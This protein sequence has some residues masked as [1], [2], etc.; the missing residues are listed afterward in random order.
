MEDKNKKNISLGSIF[1]LLISLILVIIGLYIFISFLYKG[2][3]PS[4]LGTV[5]IYLI[6]FLTPLIPSIILFY[7]FKTTAIFKNESIN[8]TGAGA[9]YVFLV[10]MLFN[11]V[12]PDDNEITIRAIVKQNGDVAANLPYIITPIRREGRTDQFGMLELTVASVSL[13]DSLTFIFQVH[14]RNIQRVI[15]INDNHLDNLTINISDKEVVIKSDDTVPKNKQMSGIDSLKF[16]VS[17]EN[18]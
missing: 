11:T 7:F 17:P 8:I 1:T 12:A 3:N 6:N 18:D 14:S 9:F 4:R 2:D 10:I 5:G 15:D 16:F 13:R